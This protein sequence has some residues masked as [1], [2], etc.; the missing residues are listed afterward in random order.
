M[1]DK[2]KSWNI[3]GLSPEVAYELTIQKRQAL[4]Q[5]HKIHL[6]FVSECDFRDELE[7]SIE[8]GEFVKPLIVEKPKRLIARFVSTVTTRIDS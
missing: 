4:M 7:Q 8:N 5:K 6:D 1:K 2:K 3:D